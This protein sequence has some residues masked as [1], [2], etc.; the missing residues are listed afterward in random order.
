MDVIDENYEFTQHF[1]SNG[2]NI[3]IYNPL[4]SALIINKTT[5]RK[6]NF[7]ELAVMHILK[8]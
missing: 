6:Y 1:N 8:T 5:P 2:P 4:F 7:N 3:F